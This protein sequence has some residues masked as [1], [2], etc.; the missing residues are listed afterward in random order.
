[1]KHGYYIAA[2]D[3]CYSDEEYCDELREIYQ[4]HAI[5]D[6]KPRYV[7]GASRY[8]SPE[9]LK[10]VVIVDAEVK[11]VSINGEPTNA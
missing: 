10:I 1:M 7:D 9:G 5:E 4:K 6:K 11:T 8:D 3:C 2:V